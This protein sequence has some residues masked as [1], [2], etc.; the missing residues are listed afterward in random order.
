M[1]RCDVDKKDKEYGDD[2]GGVHE[3]DGNTDSLVFLSI[4]RCIYRLDK[5]KVDK[6]S[7]RAY[8]S[9][10]AVNSVQPDTYVTECKV[11]SPGMCQRLVYL[12]KK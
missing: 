2:V 8:D 9:Y 6:G 3:Q 10:E 11:K 12:F 7:D 5:E 4:F 1:P